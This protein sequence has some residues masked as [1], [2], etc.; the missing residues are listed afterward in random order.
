MFIVRFKYGFLK[1]KFLFSLTETSMN[2]FMNLEI[3]EKTLQQF[4]KANGIKKLSFFGSTL[5]DKFSDASDLDVL[6]EFE[7]DSKPGFLGMAKLERELSELLCIKVDLRTPEELSR[8]IREDI[9]KEAVE[10][11]G[12]QL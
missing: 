8:H 6:V 4:C 7:K 12:I 3:N 2:L 5:T 9:V 1:K 11:Y 10:K